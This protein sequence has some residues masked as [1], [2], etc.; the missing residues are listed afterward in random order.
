MALVAFRAARAGEQPR[1][2]HRVDGQRGD[3]EREHEHARGGRAEQVA[4]EEALLAARLDEDA[5]D[6]HVPDPGDRH[7]ADP[8]P[9][10]RPAQ[11]GHT[12]L[13]AT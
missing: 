3:G 4:G 5:A 11:R 9:W 13:V 10:K 7:D 1:D 6:Q 2:D 8:R 12:T